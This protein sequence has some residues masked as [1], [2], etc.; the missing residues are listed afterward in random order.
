MNKD[1]VVNAKEIQDPTGAY[2]DAEIA[3]TSE[4]IIID[5]DLCSTYSDIIADIDGFNIALSLVHAHDE[6]DMNNLSYCLSMY[7]SNLYK[8]KPLR[9]KLFLSKIG[10]ACDYCYGDLGYSNDY[11]KLK[12]FIYN[13]L[14]VENGYNNFFYDRKKILGDDIIVIL[15]KDG[16]SNPNQTFRKF[17]C[18]EFLDFFGK[19]LRNE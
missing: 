13:N 1:I 2:I 16:I 18:D 19:G 17:V 3:K 11:D 7:Y 14:Q 6:D 10:Q 15:G 8:Y 9:Y 4:K 12:Y 5:E